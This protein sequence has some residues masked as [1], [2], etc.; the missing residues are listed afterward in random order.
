M[1]P[2]PG[3][4]FRGIGFSQ[5]NTPRVPT[6]SIGSGL[7]QIGAA[8]KDVAGVLNEIED[9]DGR[10]YAQKAISEIR[11]KRLKELQDAEL[12]GNPLDGLTGRLSQ[13]I[14]DD[15]AAYAE[16]DPEGKA[17]PSR[18]GHY[19]EL[20]K[21][22]VL[23]DLSL[24]AQRLEGTDRVNRRIASIGETLRNAATAASTDPTL[25]P[26]LWAEG[27]ALID[28]TAMPFEAREKARG[29]L[30]G[31]AAS[32]IAGMIER[33]PYAAAQQLE[34]G[35]WDKYLDPNDRV[36]L[37]NGAQAGVR[38]REAEARAR[39]AE[40]RAAAAE[41]AG[42][43]LAG[44]DD[45]FAY[46]AAGNPPDAALEA[47]YSP[48]AIAA[49]PI[50]NAGN[51]AKKAADVQIRGDAMLAVRAAS[52]PEER[53][54][55]ADDVMI[56]ASNPENYQFNAE[57]ARLVVSDI[58]NFEAQLEKAPGD[59]AF[60]SS[61]VQ[62]AVDSGNG[63]SIV[64]ASYAEQERLGVPAFKRQPLSESYAASVADQIATLPP[65]QQA[66]ALQDMAKSYGSYW[67]DVLKQIGGKLPGPLAVAA[68]M[69][70]GRAATRVAETAG[71]KIDELTAG[72]DKDASR[73]VDEAISDNERFASLATVLGSQVGGAKTLGQY[74]EAIKR[75]ALLLMRE[76]KS[77]AEA[78]EQ[79]TAEITADIDF[80]SVGQSV[81]AIPTA[82]NPDMVEA[83]LS[84]I[85]SNFDVTDVDLPPSATG[86]NE[87][88]VKAA[89]ASSIRRNGQ[90]V[91]D[92]SGKGVYLYVEGDPVTRG[93]APVLF[94]WDD[95]KAAGLPK[96]G[97]MF[98][99]QR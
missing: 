59:V 24:S 2:L 55:I 78:V 85:A 22:D 97:F 18:A 94:T 52:S 67:P 23:G 36:S 38:S 91:P 25:F 42:E 10:I 58:Q 51:L 63:V 82:A 89:Y 86:M 46:R 37:Y 95:L 45:Y 30:R 29:D 31:V 81:V 62:A 77:E 88:D 65:D 74:G 96:D 70:E 48:E 64:S 13:G 34:S 75:S 57:T 32:A 19:L 60:G 50:K 66:A 7:Q 83:G 4:E 17:A 21:S 47:K 27:N 12:S 54:A 87:A 43:Y 93:G 61:R 40:S 9:E 16:A 44:A 69:P 1:P 99:G 39:A 53:R 98:E 26:K 41:A 80:R 90:W 3:V 20:A 14:E 11:L 76:G 49:L 35:A 71:L 33:N 28:S 79:A 56:R 6:D 84:S 73:N 15:F 92:G 8:F 68:T 5:P 72:L